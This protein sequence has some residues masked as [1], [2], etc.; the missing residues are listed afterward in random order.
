MHVDFIKI[1]GSFIRRLHE[2]RSDQGITKAMAT[3]AKDMDMKTIAE[4][5]EQEATLQFL[6]E[7]GV[8]YAQG[9]LIGKPSPV[10]RF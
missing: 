3:V 7:F 9:F 6:K 5:V 8:D 1:D 4:F 10:P 2:H